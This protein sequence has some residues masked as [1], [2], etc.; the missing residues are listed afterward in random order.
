MGSKHNTAD[1]RFHLPRSRYRVGLHLLLLSSLVTALSEIIA[2]ALNSRAKCL[3][4]GVAALLED[5]ADPA[6]NLAPW[7]ARLYAHPIMR[8]L[9]P[10]ATQG[11]GE[12]PRTEGKRPFLSSGEQLCDGAPLKADLEA[13]A[14]RWPAGAGPGV[15][16]RLNGIAN[17]IPGG[18]LSFVQG[19]LRELAK[20][21]TPGGLAEIIGQIP[22]TAPESAAVRDGLLAL[23]PPP[24]IGSVSG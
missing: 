18:G 4:Q 15:G 22:T 12:Y 11:A 6:S 16:V 10:L 17:E 24:V 1:V 3:W 21:P 13:V 2:N 8:P 9:F 23:L 5:S 19:P 20:N 7:T 14:A